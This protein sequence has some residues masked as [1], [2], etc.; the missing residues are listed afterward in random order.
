MSEEVRG[1]F[2]DSVGRLMG[3][4][5]RGEMP[6]EGDI[7]RVMSV[8]GASIV[9]PEEHGSVALQTLF[10]GPLLTGNPDDLPK[11]NRPE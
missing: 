11:Y 7:Q 5:V 1:A 4:L 8:E 9:L 10:G 6:D 2:L 3:S